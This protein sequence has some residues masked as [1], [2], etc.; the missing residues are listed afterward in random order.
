MIVITD[1]LTAPLDEGA[2]VAT[3]NL[4]TSLKETQYC[5]IVSLQ[6][7]HSFEL[8]NQYFNA[9]KLLLNGKMLRSIR[10]NNHRKILYIPG[11]SATP[12]SFIRA[13]ILQ[14]IT[15]KD[16]YLL[17]LQPRRYKLFFKFLA[18]NI[19]PQ[20]IISQSNK[21]SH[22]LS[23]LKIKNE[24]LPL[25]VNTDK[26]YQLSAEQRKSL[27]SQ[28]KIHPQKKVL[29]H[30]GHIQKS[31]N[32]DWLTH[33]K[34]NNPGI[35][36]I[37]VGSTFNQDDEGL[38]AQLQKSGIRIIR[39]FTPQLE[40]IYNLADYYIFPVLRNDGAI[41]TPLSVI[42]A[43]ACNLP[44]IT[45]KFGSLPDTFSADED[46]HYV[47]SAEEI[48][49]LVKKKRILPCRNRDKIS[50]FTWKEIAKKLI[51]IVEQ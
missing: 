48:V 24:V 11:A 42:E 23:K 45:T 47:E 49:Q 6:P 28:Y 22:Y 41:E 4:I 13:K 43:M 46:F 30:V 2:K 37:I 17:A 51:D 34:K 27:R 20:C 39:E 33:I 8:V 19:S 36:V 50:P 16:V 1:I 21:T 15:K 38:F 35:E 5:H 9:N 31:R 32:L 14:L 40:E 25:G 7:K 10:L 18:Q 3:F 29:L 44:I 12:F 26:Y